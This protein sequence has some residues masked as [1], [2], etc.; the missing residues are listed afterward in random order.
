MHLRV[1]MYCK[2]TQ[3]CEYKYK[4]LFFK[5]CEST[6]LLQQYIISLSKIC[7]TVV[8]DVRNYVFIKLK[9]K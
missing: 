4:T 8:F 3:Q 7:T 5:I 2:Y 1:K 6:K 9:N